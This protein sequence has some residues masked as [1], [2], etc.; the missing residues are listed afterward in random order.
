MG[1]KEVKRESIFNWNKK[2]LKDAL[3][4]AD[5]PGLGSFYFLCVCRDLS[6][7]QPLIKQHMGGGFICRSC[8]C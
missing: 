6:R 5:T 3:L 2:E 8:E 7:V 4:T 1:L